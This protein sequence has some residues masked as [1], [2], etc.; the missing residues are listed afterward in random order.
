YNAAL[1]LMVETFGPRGV[2]QP[3]RDVIF[4]CRHHEPLVDARRTIAGNAGRRQAGAINAAAAEIELHV[5]RP[6]TAW[7]FLDAPHVGRQ[8]GDFL[9]GEPPAVSLAVGAVDERQH[10]DR[11]A[12]RRLS[13][14][15]PCPETRHRPA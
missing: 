7:A 11:R 12:R 2:A 15:R 5:E 14:D 10:D 13:I 4:A 6:A 3:D 8:L 1:A 9:R